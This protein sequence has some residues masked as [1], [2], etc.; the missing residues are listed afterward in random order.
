[1]RDEEEYDEAN[2]ED[3]RFAN[4]EVDLQ[5]GW[6]FNRNAFK[7]L[8]SIDGFPTSGY[9]EFAKERR[10]F[11]RNSQGYFKGNLYPIPF[12]NMAAWD[13]DTSRNTGF[14]SKSDYQKW[15]RSTRFPILREWVKKHRPRLLVCAGVTA[16]PEYID[17]FGIADLKV[18]TFSVNGYKKAVYYG[19]LPTHAPAVIV[20]H[21]SGGSHGLNSNEA[22]GLVGS[23]IRGELLGEF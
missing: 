22:I 23:F 12:N 3:T 19:E 17:A 13:A 11:E 21:L 2:H 8:S 15:C 7:L 10:I 9:R 14:S 5:L 4:Y 6:P 20:P 18:A 16:I 1:M